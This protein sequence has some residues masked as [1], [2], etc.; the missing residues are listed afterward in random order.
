M[1][2]ERIKWKSNYIIVVSFYSPNESSSS[3]LDTISSGLIER[4]SRLNISLK[5]LVG[6]FPEEN[7]ST[8]AECDI[9]FLAPDINPRKYGVSVPSERFQHSEGLFLAL[10]FPV[11]FS[12]LVHD[13][14]SSDNQIILHSFPL[15]PFRDL[16]NL[17]HCR[18]HS[19]LPRTRKIV[20]V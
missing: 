6:K 15:E 11:H 12:V 13:R 14:V 3:D 20:R 2:A 10:R 8:F 19:E 7:I 16:V 18:R 4:I 9:L 17:V 1:P 5:H